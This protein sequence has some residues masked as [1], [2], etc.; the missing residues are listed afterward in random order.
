MIAYD[1]LHY[2]NFVKNKP[3][4]IKNEIRKKNTEL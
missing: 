2:D 4:F 3:F 1:N